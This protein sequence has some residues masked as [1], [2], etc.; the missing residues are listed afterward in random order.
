M[1]GELHK[2]SGS[3]TR[4]HLGSAIRRGRREQHSDALDIVDCD[5][6]L[7]PGD[8]VCWA[9]PRTAELH[10]GSVRRIF[11]RF[12]EIDTGAGLASRSMVYTH[13][14]ALAERVDTDANSA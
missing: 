1:A 12:A 4:R 10:E 14:L 9:H 6:P 7:R 2:R 3:T 13:R 8:R 11:D 5:T